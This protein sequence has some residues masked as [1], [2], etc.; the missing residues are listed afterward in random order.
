MVNADSSRRR[1]NFRH[2]TP[3]ENHSASGVATNTAAPLA[4]PKAA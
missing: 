2:Q 4:A 1:N 3:S